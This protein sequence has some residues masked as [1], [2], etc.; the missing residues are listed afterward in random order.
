MKLFLIY[1]NVQDNICIIFNPKCINDY[2]FPSFCI[3]TMV[4]MFFLWHF[5]INNGIILTLKVFKTPGFI[6]VIYIEFVEIR[7]DDHMLF[8]YNG[9]EYKTPPNVS[10]NRREKSRLQQLQWEQRIMEEK[11]KN[12][13]ALLT[14]TIAEK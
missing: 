14:K 11:N 5:Y 4:S 7:L 12:T 6:K 3:V 9:F 2:L 10:Y 8:C 13:K 1:I